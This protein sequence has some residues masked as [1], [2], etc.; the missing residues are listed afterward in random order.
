M[1]LYIR[2]NERVTSITVSDQLCHMLAV[3][4]ATKFSQYVWNHE[5]K[6]RKLVQRWINELV[7][8]TPAPDSNVS[9]WVQAQIVVEIADPLIIEKRERLQR[10]Q[11]EKLEI[12]AAARSTRLSD[13]NH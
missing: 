5:F 8:H 1:R 12:F 11:D 10:E 7:Q 6:G 4:L 2:K 3:K 9:Q 13:R